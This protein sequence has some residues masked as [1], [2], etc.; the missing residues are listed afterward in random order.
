MF[1]PTSKVYFYKNIPLD[2]SQVNQRLFNSISEQNNY[3]ASLNPILQN[4]TSDYIKDRQRFACPCNAEDLRNVNYM[5]FQDSNYGTKWIYCFVTEIEY[6]NPSCCYVY[7]QVD[8]FQTYFLDLSIKA[9]YVEREHVND[10][11]VGSN[12][13]YE[14][15]NLGDYIVNQRIRLL[16]DDT[17]Y[18]CMLSTVDP[19][20]NLASTGASVHNGVLFG[21][22]IWATT[23]VAVLKGWIEAIVDGGKQDGVLDIFMVPSY[24][25]KDSI[26]QNYYVGNSSVATTTTT[27]NTKLTTLDGYT[28]RNK[29]LLTYPYVATEI[30]NSNGSVQTFKQERFANKL[31]F[32]INSIISSGVGTICTPLNYNG[33]NKNYDYAI[34]LSVFPQ[35]QWYNNP[36][37]KWLNDNTGS[38]VASAV[39]STVQG[40]GSGA[41]MG[42]VQGGA[43]GGA[44]G[45]LGSIINSF[46]SAINEQ[47]KPVSS[48]GTTSNTVL[49]AL[50]DNAFTLHKVSIKSEYAKIIDDYFDMVGYNVSRKKVPNLTG[51][52]SW[53]YVK[54]TNFSCVG[55]C[56]SPSIKA[57]KDMF[58]R[59]VTLWHTN[60]VGNYGLSNSIV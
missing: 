18:Y 22:G 47:N 46:G 49:S 3:F 45:F 12:T 21:G 41:M 32:E 42:G 1:N 15:V 13:T 35:C 16:D 31:E 25:L 55:A 48:I 38:N 54:T 14:G 28:P 11:T 4:A 9:C 26:I 6:V 34:S 20:N 33:D 29:K 50:K 43:L 57:I 40:I 60:D 44:L 27:S 56:P 30:S 51:R 52:Q 53:N 10:D 5:R 58:N 8:D 7:F 23:D 2:V 17:Y 19:T 39:G 36:Y 59:G 37:A 24:A